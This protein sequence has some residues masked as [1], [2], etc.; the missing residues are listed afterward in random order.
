MKLT[1]LVSRPAR[2]APWSEG[3]NIP[4]N[5]PDFSRR[6]LEQHLTQEH[7]AASRRSETIDAHVSWIHNDLLGAK[8]ARILDL[9]CGPGLYLQR[10]AKLG[11]TCTGIDYSPASIE[12]ARREAVR[13]G[14]EITYQLADLR[15]ADFGSGY[16][17]VMQIYGELNVFKPADANLILRK[18]YAALNEKGVVMFEVQDY[19]DVRRE[20]LAGPGWYTSAAGLFSDQPYLAL[21]ENFWDETAQARTG[22]YY[23][24]DCA[25]GEVAF[26]AQSAQAYRDEA[27]V[28]LFER[29]GFQQVKILPAMS[30]DLSLPRGNFFPILA[31]KS[32]LE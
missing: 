21:Q 29:N 3:D 8:P 1:D 30:P 14:L 13:E 9:G 10:L 11:H 2:P 6:M 5:D 25:S 26:Y 28:A 4:W 7:D 22:R 31:C 17:L 27:Y 16:D 19:E 23:V 18:A 15:E 12:Y 32:C 20:G 24:V